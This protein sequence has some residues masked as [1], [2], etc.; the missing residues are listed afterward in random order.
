MTTVRQYLHL[1]ICKNYKISTLAYWYKHHHVSVIEGKNVTM[2]WDFP[3]NTNR[4]VQVKK[5]AIKENTCRPI[6]VSDKSLSVKE[7][8]KLI[9]CKGQEIEF[10]K[11]VAY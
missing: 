11:D 7:F 6:D 8:Y 10:K 9:K 2:L 5:R 1:K 4:T 3:I